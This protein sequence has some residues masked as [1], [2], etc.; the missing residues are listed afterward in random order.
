[1]G[2]LPTTENPE[3]NREE[4]KN[5]ILALTETVIQLAKEGKESSEEMRKARSEQREEIDKLL[6]S[7][8]E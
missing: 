2:E 7:Y 5:K 1:M 4:I 8:E 6:A 3:N